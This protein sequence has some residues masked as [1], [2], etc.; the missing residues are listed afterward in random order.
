[1]PTHEQGTRVLVAPVGHPD[2]ARAHSQTT[3][4]QHQTLLEMIPLLPGCCCIA[5][6][7]ASVGLSVPD[8]LSISTSAAHSTAKAGATLPVEECSEDF[9]VCILGE[10]GRLLAHDCQTSPCSQ[11]KWV[12]AWTLG[13]F[14]LFCHWEML[15]APFLTWE[16]MRCPVGEHRRTVLAQLLGTLKTRAARFTKWMAPR[17]S[18]PRGI[19]F[20]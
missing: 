1:M 3:S 10:L 8:F 7:P 5:L 9:S 11:H 15:H 20:W 18:V 14:H 13:P 16:V 17:S 4:N 2:F 6:R 19:A 12:A